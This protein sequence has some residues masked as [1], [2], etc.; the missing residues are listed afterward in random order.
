MKK[1]KRILITGHDG[2]LGSH[3]VNYLSKNYEIVGLSKNKQPRRPDIQQIKSDIR[4]ITLKS[5]PKDIYCIIHLAAITDVKYCQNEPTECFDVNVKGTQ[6]LLEL[7]RKL[8]SKFIYMS[9]SH[10]YGVPKKNPITEEH[11]KNPTSIYSAS[12]LAGEIM[13]ESY[14][15]TYNMPITILRLFSVY[16]PNSPTHLVTSRI[17]SQMLSGNLLKLGNLKPKRDFI[18]I[19]DVI[20]VIELVLKKSKGFNSYNVGTGRSYSIKEVCK[21]LEEISN[22]KIHVKS[23]K[24]YTRKSDIDNFVSDSSKLK[25]L[26]WI[27]K[28]EFKEGLFQ[29]YNWFKSEN[30]F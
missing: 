9:T 28:T 25:K 30:Q 2:F 19:Q 26:G 1:L 13:C 29:T 17:I 18:Y 22:K 20:N 27:P 7:A 6:N 24:I 15:K 10:V 5:I 16:G 21:F 4:K 12:K 14:A 8:N 23:V 3:L 11:P